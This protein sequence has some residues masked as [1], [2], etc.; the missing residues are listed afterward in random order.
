MSKL[1]KDVTDAINELMAKAKDAGKLDLDDSDVRQ[2]LHDAA[3]AYFDCWWLYGQAAKQ[4]DGRVTGEQED[5]SY[6]VRSTRWRAGAAVK[7]EQAIEIMRLVL[8]CEDEGDLG[9]NSFYPAVLRNLDEDAAIVLAREGSVC[10]YVKRGTSD[11]LNDAYRDGRVSAV[12]D[13]MDCD[14]L[15]FDKTYYRLWWD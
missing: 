15:D 1:A 3:V 12:V 5:K 6:D 7:V 9:Y 4:P 2:T 10:V 14:E 8:G 13:E 11:Y